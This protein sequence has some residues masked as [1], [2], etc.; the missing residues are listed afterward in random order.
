MCRQ[1]FKQW[2]HCVLLCLLCLTS[3]PGSA[4][5]VLAHSD[6]RIGISVAVPDNWTVEQ[7][8]N[9]FALIHNSRLA[10][11]VFGLQGIPG[12]EY[13]TREELDK[14]TD[15]YYSTE[16]L[17]EVFNKDEI[18]SS[19]LE[20]LSKGERKYVVVSTKNIVLDGI[21]AVEF[22]TIIKRRPVRLGRT[23]DEDYI[24]EKRARSLGFLTNGGSY[25]VTCTC[26]AGDF[27]IANRAF[28][29][30]LRS[31]NLHN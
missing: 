11:C 2:L 1:S 9:G 24:V 18:Q 13:L 10:N 22:L 14:K 15:L 4:A 8:E 21:K 25:N 7:R 27:E 26:G 20:K 19:L 16:N 6:A 29:V 30:I 5:E 28:D 12:V 23:M 17:Q 31:I 3:N